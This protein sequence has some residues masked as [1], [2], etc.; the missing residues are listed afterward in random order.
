[1][2]N[3][4][5][6]H[7]WRIGLRHPSKLPPTVGESARASKLENLAQ[8]RRYLRTHA[9]LRDILGQLTT[10]RLE[11]AL[12]EHGKPYL[13]PAPELRFNLAHSGDLALVAAALDVEV[14][15]DVERLRP[16]PG[17]A[18]IAERYL[19]PSHPPPRSAPAFFRCWT[20]FEAILKAQGIGLYGAGSEIEGEWMVR[21]LDTGS[22]GYV[23]AV[24][25]ARDGLTLQMHDYGGEA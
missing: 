22:R 10:A 11:F 6:L 20:Q 13:P 18:A 14:G 24:A 8:R 16:M 17:Y 1:M 9:A 7:V 21:E 5:E 23:A 2:L 4:G 12:H 3:A 25:A 19:P 15:V